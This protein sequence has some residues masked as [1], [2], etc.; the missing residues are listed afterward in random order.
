[1]APK[2]SDTQAKVTDLQNRIIKL[3]KTIDSQTA[4]IK[5]LQKSV[6]TIVKKIA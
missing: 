4:L 5:A 1:M 3:E 6:N 2:V